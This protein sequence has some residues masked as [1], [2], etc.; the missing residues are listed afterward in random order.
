[1][2][3]PSTLCHG[4]V[5]WIFARK[6]PNGTV[7]RAGARTRQK[8]TSHEGLMD[9]GHYNASL[10]NIPVSDL[11]RIIKKKKLPMSVEPVSR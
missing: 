8:G 9:V 11:L 4:S 3:Q 5:K 1:M 6:V 2:F 7:A 10:V